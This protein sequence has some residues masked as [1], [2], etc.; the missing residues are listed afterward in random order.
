LGF[1]CTRQSSTLTGAVKRGN[2]GKDKK[3]G[4]HSVAKFPSIVMSKISKY[5]R[6][7]E[8]EEP[9]MID[10]KKMQAQI[11]FLFKFDSNKISK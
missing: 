1:P 6:N 7:V 10:M 11:I 2:L 3:Y 8:F 5:F 4:V 9:E